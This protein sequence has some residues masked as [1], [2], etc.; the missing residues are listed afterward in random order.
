MKIIKKDEYEL[1]VD[2][3]KTKQYYQ[4]HSL[5]NCSG[6]K[7][8]YD[9]IKGLFPELESFLSDFGVDIARPDEIA[10]FDIED[11]IYYNPMYTVSG[12]ILCMGEYEIDVD[13]LNI[14]ID[15]GYVPNEQ[16]Q[17]YFVITVYNF[18]LPWVLEEPFPKTPQ[19][20]SLISRIKGLFK[21]NW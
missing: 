5:C 10:W 15:S 16:T 13:T 12:K 18:R 8:F 17:S 7:N 21:K 6:C 2:I 11:E 9:Q 4:T 14:V 3:E 19:K 1:L 20:Q